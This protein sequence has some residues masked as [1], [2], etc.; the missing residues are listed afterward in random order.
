MNPRELLSDFDRELVDLR[1]AIKNFQRACT[2]AGLDE[3]GKISA[4]MDD[5]LAALPPEKTVGM[6]SAGGAKKN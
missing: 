5:A 6:F 4:A 1:I 3:S 2:R